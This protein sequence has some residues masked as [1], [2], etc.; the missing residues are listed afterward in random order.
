MQ[1]TPKQGGR[2]WLYG[3]L[4][5]GGL[6]LLL[7]VVM[8]GCGALLA[9][10]DGD[11]GSTGGGSPDS[12]GETGSDAG[13][14]GEGADEGGDSG[15]GADGTTV[16]LGEPGT[17][18]DWT[19]TVH[20][21]ETSPTYGDEFLEE[22][23]QGEFAI[24]SMTVSNEGDEAVTFDSSA[25]TLRDAD[26]KEYSSQTVLGSDS[27]FLEQIN[28]GNSAEGEAVVDVPEGTEITQVVIEDVWSF[29]S[30]PLVVEVS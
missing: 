26:G 11:G 4:G 21:I 13:G 9:G 29:T 20:G 15:G 28:P 3:C 30:D 14:D 7:L 27:L 2:G 5:C 16:G 22:Q 8:V 17:A 6:A 12:A 1:A 10:G 18:A 24:V 23:A 19:V 25:V